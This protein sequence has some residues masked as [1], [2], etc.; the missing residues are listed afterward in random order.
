VNDRHDVLKDSNFWLVLEFG[1]CGW[2]RDCGDTSVGGFWCD[3][4]SPVSARNTKEGIEV[5]GIAWIAKGN[6]SQHEFSFVASIPQRMLRGKRANAAMDDVTIDLDHKT[7]RFSVV[8]ASKS[9]NNKLQ[10]KRGV[11]SGRADG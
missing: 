8:P 6:E 4:F 5:S 10:R 9:P 1:M 2:F 7:L 11:A 3:G